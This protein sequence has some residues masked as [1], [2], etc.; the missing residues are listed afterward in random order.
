MYSSL[1]NLAMGDGGKTPR[2]HSGWIPSL[3]LMYLLLWL[4][5]VP[6]QG[7][8][9]PA[10]KWERDAWQTYS[11]IAEKEE[12]PGYFSMDGFIYYEFFLY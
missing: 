11:S 5:K 2:P 1:R 12:R 8:S 6:L 7:T 3:E 10:R 4:L 9:V